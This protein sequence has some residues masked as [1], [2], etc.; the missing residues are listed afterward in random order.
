MDDLIGTKTV[1]EMLGKSVDTIN[2]WVKEG[3]ITPTIEMP[4]ETGARLYRRS[5]VEALLAEQ[6]S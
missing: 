5:D 4:G 2:R 1:A 3:R 6:T